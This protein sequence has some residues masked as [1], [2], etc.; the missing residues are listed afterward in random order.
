MGVSKTDVIQMALENLSRTK[1]LPRENKVEIP[2]SAATMKRASR[3]HVTYGYGTTL[4]MLLSE[5]TDIGVREI[6]RKIDLDRKEDL[7]LARTD[8]DAGAVEIQQDSMTL[9]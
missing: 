8:M 4:V 9:S 6:R 7:Q 1:V 5:A 2:I 3:L